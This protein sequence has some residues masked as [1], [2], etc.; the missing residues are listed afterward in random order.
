NYYYY[1]L[2]TYTK[3]FRSYLKLENM[4]VNNVGLPNSSQGVV[5]GA[6]FDKQTKRRIPFNGQIQ[7]GNE[8]YYVISQDSSKYKDW[9]KKINITDRKS[10]RL[11]FSYVSIS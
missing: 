1:K 3:I 2:V 6:F 7:L 10:T 8:Y 4:N 9:K 11:N 5:N